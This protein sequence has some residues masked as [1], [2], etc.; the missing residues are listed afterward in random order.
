MRRKK[1]SHKKER[2]FVFGVALLITAVLIVPSF[3]T[4]KEI[5]VQENTMSS[6][7]ASVL[8]Q[9]ERTKTLMEEERRIQQDDY[10]ERVARDTLGLAKPNEIILKP[11][12]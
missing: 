10:I 1:Y 12:R 4:S 9:K 2:N 7:R 6:L 8:E 3:E 5:K 11:Q